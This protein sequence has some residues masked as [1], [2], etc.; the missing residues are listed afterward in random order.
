MAQATASTDEEVLEL[1][2]YLGEVCNC[3]LLVKSNNYGNIDC[4][5]D[6]PRTYVGGERGGNDSCF[7]GELSDRQCDCSDCMGEDR[8]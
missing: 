6:Y 8:A 2:K 3:L 1:L 5:W 7:A 4:E